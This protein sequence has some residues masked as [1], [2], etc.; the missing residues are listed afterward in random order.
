MNKIEQ[1]TQAARLWLDPA[2]RDVAEIRLDDLLNPTGECAIV[3][4]EEGPNECI[5]VQ[6]EDGRVQTVWASSGLRL[7]PKE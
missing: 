1:L 7:V 4:I 3:S 5:H 2:Q 6:F